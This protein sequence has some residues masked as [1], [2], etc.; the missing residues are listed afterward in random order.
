MHEMTPGQVILIKKTWKIFRSIDPVLI[1]DT[2]YSKLFA[3]TP[4]LRHLFPPKMDAQ[5]AKLIDMLNVVVA[6]LDRFDE[7]S[8]DIEAMAQRHVQYGVRPAHYKLVG[9]ALLW[10]LQQ[11]LGPDWTTEV[12]EA[13]NSCY[14]AL[15]DAM[16]NAVNTHG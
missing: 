7:L 2:F 11:G 16:I 6:R 14:T 3:D 4:R 10:T 5:Y 9:T 15:A 12:R 1:G 8:A 13:W